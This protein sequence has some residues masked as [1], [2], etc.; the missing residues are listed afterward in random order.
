MID[1]M[2]ITCYNMHQ[3]ATKHLRP[4]SV[5]LPSCQWQSDKFIQNAFL[6]VKP[7]LTSLPA[8]WSTVYHYEFYLLSE[9]TVKFIVIEKRNSLNHLRTFKTYLSDRLSLAAATTWSPREASQ[10]RLSGQSD[11]LLLQVQCACEEFASIIYK[12][13]QTSKMSFF[14]WQR[15]N[16]RYFS[17][18]YP[19]AG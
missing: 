18:T 10:K 11:F 15:Q 19:C 7:R 6:G 1:R 5:M 3:H 8:H 14:N 12:Y 4:V 2:A 17:W 13:I 16:T 9:M